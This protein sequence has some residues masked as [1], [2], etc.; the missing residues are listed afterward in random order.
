MGKICGPRPCAFNCLLL[1]FKQSIHLIDEGHDLIRV[2][3]FQATRCTGTD[4]CYPTADAIK[5]RK[6]DSD[7]YPGRHEQHCCHHDKIGQHSRSTCIAR[8]NKSPL[9]DG[10][11]DSYSAFFGIG[12]E[13]DLALADDECLS[14][15]SRQ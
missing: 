12:L 3:A 5:R 13:E 7:L 2:Y 4:V 6:P 11:G 9:I 1:S 8:L 15:R 14:S 10:Y